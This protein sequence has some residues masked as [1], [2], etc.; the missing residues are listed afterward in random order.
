MMVI[1]GHLKSDSEC[2]STDVLKIINTPAIF[3]SI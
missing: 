3:L 2:V 1:L